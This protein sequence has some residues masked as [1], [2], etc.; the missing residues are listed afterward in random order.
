MREIPA[1]AGQL[2]NRVEGR[3]RWSRRSGQILNSFG[4]PIA[5]PSNSVE[6]RLVLVELPFRQSS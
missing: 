6:S 5:Y 1:D 3:S 4:D 2:R